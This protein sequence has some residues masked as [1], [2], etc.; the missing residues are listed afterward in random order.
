M[1]K[2][3]LNNLYKLNKLA[4]RTKDGEFAEF[5]D[6]IAVELGQ[7]AI[8]DIKSGPSSNS[9]DSDVQD[10]PVGELYSLINEF[11]EQVLEIIQAIV[12]E[13]DIDSSNLL[14]SGA[15]VNKALDNFVSEIAE[16]IAS[17]LNLNQD[18]QD[19]MVSELTGP[20]AVMPEGP[21]AVMSKKV[22]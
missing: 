18:D 2:I 22:K 10:N 8:G 1:D 21:S 14:S 13:P 7:E 11:R 12:D 4:S 20:S 3:S 17:E 6:K 15:N 19:E 16:I 5:L 9:I